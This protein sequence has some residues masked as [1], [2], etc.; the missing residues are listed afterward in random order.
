MSNAENVKKE[1][2]GFPI[3]TRLPARANTPRGFGGYPWVS[4]FAF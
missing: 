1:R 2:R 4:V 3:D